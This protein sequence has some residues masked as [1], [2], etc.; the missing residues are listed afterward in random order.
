[1]Q[2]IKIQKL[3]SKIKQQTQALETAPMKQLK[4]IIE[5]SQEIQVMTEQLKK[6]EENF[7]GIMFTIELEKVKYFIVDRIGYGGF[8]KVYRAYD[9][10]LKKYAVKQA[11]RFS[12]ET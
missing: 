1:M 4:P 3:E 9:K 7:Q 2:N 8:G 10:N 11:N 6:L 5:Q 12:D